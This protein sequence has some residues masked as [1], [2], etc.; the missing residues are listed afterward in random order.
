[1]MN[2][3]IRIIFIVIILAAISQA[4]AQTAPLSERM[5]DTAKDRIW[6]DSP[7]GK[8]IP[9]KWVYDFGVILNGMKTKWH[10]T[11]DRRYFD[12]IKRGVDAFVNDDGTIKTYRVDEYNI[13]QVRMGSAV[14]MLYRVTGEAKYK[15]AADLIRSQLK[16]H[17]RTNEGGFWHKKIY[18]Y[19]MWLDG[20]YM[21]EPFYAEY[22]QVF[23]E[24]NWND[25]TNQFIWM[26]SHVRDDKTGLLYHG[27]DESKKMPWADKA[28][29]RA[30]M[31]W[32][33][34][35][36]WYAMALVD[37]LDYLP[38]DHPRRGELITILTREMTALEK[39]QDKRT[40]LWWLIL[41]MPDKKGNY[42]EASA[43]CMFTYAMAKGVR[44]GY[45]PA[46]FM[47]PAKAAWSGIQKE[48]VESRDGGVNLLKT[49]GGAGLGGNPYRDGSFDY[50]A[51]E[52][53][54]TN[55]PKGIGAFILAAVEMENTGGAASA[56]GGRGKTVLLDDYFNHELKKDGAGDNS[57][58]EITWHY[59]WDE[60]SNGGYY[61]WGDVFGRLGATTG[62]LSSAPTASNLAGANIY[63]IVD[64]D[65]DKETPKPNF[66]LTA[67]IKAIAGWVKKGG[68]LVLMANDTGNCEFTHL[69]EL[70]KTFGITFNGDSLNRVQGTQFEQGKISVTSP[71]PVFATAKTL[72]LK[73][74]SSLSLSK[75][76]TPLLSQDGK[77]LMATARFGKGTVFAVG[78][79]WLYDE[80]T[81]GRK[82]PAE[83]ENFKAMNDLS[84]WLLAQ[85]K[86]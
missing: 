56:T 50:Y 83:Y 41:D 82:L 15:K 17:P 64:P 36:G 75:P 62:T 37:V 63:I 49:I 47:T 31:F 5:A 81:D 70:A 25:I 38:K 22:S 9:P 58:R 67:D 33:R 4:F 74:I 80:Y 32:G 10:A 77:V 71:D 8:G 51:G 61:L 21:G 85:V 84:R 26:E 23:D 7:N 65:T 12:F 45:L 13:D 76:A 2:F 72:Y 43:S 20:L 11:G 29:G 14:L 60:M 86:K 30:P 42:F 53:V 68:V 18:P 69:N 44:M 1:M 59:K 19:Q 35:M 78:D 34:A 39:V 24:D 40:G 52:K 6:V 27:W 3:R 66:I 54:V 73:E 28:R 57:G 55:D 48:F 16:A 79:P 46:R